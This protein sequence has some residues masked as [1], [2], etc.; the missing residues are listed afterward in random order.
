MQSQN[1]RI[2]NKAKA[3]IWIIIQAEH[4]IELLR[5]PPFSGV[6]EQDEIIQIAKCKV[7]MQE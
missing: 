3:R 4:R 2:G 6:W 7:K 5:K 1:T